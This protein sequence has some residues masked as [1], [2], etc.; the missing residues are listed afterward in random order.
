MIQPLGYVI[1]RGEKKLFGI[2][3]KIKIKIGKEL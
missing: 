2:I 3:F 1:F